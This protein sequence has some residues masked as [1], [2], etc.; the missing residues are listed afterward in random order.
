MPVKWVPIEGDPTPTAG[1]LGRMGKSSK[2]ASTV[3]ASFAICSPH[4]AS[5]LP[6]GCE[7]KCLYWTAIQTQGHAALGAQ[8][9]C[10]PH[11][12]TSRFNDPMI[13]T[14]AHPNVSVTNYPL[15]FR[16]ISLADEAFPFHPIQ[17]IL[18]PFKRLLTVEHHH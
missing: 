14:Q 10:R 5:V 6:S 18:V 1:M 2:L 15:I 7:V 11:G 4:E 16:S 8:R 3:F 9:N 12:S 13:G 17:G